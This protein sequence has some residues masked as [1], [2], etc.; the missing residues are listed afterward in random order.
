MRFILI[1]LLLALV[2]KT[3]N[4]LVVTKD[5][6]MC[7]LSQDPYICVAVLKDKGANYDR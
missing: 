2:I 3:A 5:Y 4:M 6:P 7:R 1:L